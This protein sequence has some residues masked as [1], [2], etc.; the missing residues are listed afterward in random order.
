M[1]EKRT[2]SSVHTDDFKLPS[3]ITEGQVSD[4]AGKKNTHVLW[5]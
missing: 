4:Q 3:V 5:F 2:A 1:N